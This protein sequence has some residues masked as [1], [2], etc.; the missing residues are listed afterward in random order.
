MRRDNN[1]VEQ[2]NRLLAFELT[3]ID[4]YTSHSRQ[5]EDMGLMKL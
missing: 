5:Y 3:S 4:Q 2:L 1:V